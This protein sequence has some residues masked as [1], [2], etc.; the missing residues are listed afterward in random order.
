MTLATEIQTANPSSFYA[1]LLLAKVCLKLPNV[2]WQAEK[3][4]KKCYEMDN[5][6]HEVIYNLASIR[7]QKGDYTGAIEL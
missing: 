4:F 3:Y 1:N 5:K 2:A 6:N 7:Y